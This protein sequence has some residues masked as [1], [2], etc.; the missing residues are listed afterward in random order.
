[1]EPTQLL[2]V[3]AVILSNLLHLL[4]L[5]PLYSLTKRLYLNRSLA[6]ITCIL[7]AFSPAGAFLFAGNTESLFNFL[8][9]SGMALFHKDYR[10]LPALIWSLA[11]TVRSNAILWAGFFAWDALNTLLSLDRR[12]IPA[13]I[14]RL[15]YLSVCALI[16]IGGFLY[17]QYLAWN[18]Y[19]TSSTSQEWCSTR[20]PMIYS[21]VQNKYWYSSGCHQLISG[22]S[23]FYVTGQQINC[24]TSSLHLL[25]SSAL[26]SQSRNTYA[27]N[28]AII[29]SYRIPLLRISLLWQE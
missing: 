18:Q 16:S 15:I 2:I 29:L 27:T 7:H 1:L 9:F 10:L 23:D 25:T 22:T 5:V 14:G 3:A 11:G 20:I 26:S 13:A 6:I 8:S 21:H 19:C 4:A 17:W 24:P 12:R 28:I